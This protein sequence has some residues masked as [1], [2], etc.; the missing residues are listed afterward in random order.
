V[1][2]RDQSHSSWGYLVDRKSL[3]LLV[4]R[5]WVEDTWEVGDAASLA[6]DRS[7]FRGFEA[8]VVEVCVLVAGPCGWEIHLPWDSVG[9]MDWL[10]WAA[11]EFAVRTDWPF[12]VA[13]GYV[14]GR[15]SVFLMAQKLVGGMGLLFW[16]AQEYEQRERNHYHQNQGQQHSLAQTQQEE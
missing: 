14:R 1:L 13:E 10:S 8:Q 4:I 16:V 15:D 2:Q 9:G 6:P 11:E 7:R 12:V 3:E 5:F